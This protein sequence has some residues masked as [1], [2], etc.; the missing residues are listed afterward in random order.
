MPFLD[1]Y[2]DVRE[3]IENNDG[4]VEHITEMAP[5]ELKNLFIQH[6]DVKSQL[7]SSHI[8]VIP[9]HAILRRQIL[10][11]QATIMRSDSA[12]MRWAGHFEINVQSKK[13]YESR[14]RSYAIFWW[15]KYARHRHVSRANIK[16]REMIAVIAA[17]AMIRV[18]S[19]SFDDIFHHAFSKV[20]HTKSRDAYKL[21]INAWHAK[22]KALGS[23]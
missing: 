2:D 5:W 7:H 3:I 11:P 9:H 16:S 15:H 10:M 1:F 20:T 13:S 17:V 19:A 8:T 14:L 6:D 22:I 18:L 12:N 4:C 21:I 23:I